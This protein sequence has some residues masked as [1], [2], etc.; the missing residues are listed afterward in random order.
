MLSS[1]EFDFDKGSGAF[2]FSGIPL[3]FLFERRCFFF[4]LF[5]FFSFFHSF[6]FV[7]FQGFGLLASAHRLLRCRDDMAYLKRFVS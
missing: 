1:N 5:F 2:K 7:P 6:S 3:R 4:F